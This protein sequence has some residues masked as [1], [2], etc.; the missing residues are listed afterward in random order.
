VRSGLARALDVETLHFI[1]TIDGER[2]L[3]LSAC[4]SSTIA[5]AARGAAA[6]ECNNE[7]AA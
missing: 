1:H 5:L 7:M 4:V 2:Q 3:F 6:S